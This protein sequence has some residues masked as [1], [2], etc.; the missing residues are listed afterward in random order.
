VIPEARR[1]LASGKDAAAI[2]LLKS[3]PPTPAVRALL[4]D[5]YRIQKRYDAAIEAYDKA[6]SKA[7]GRLAERIL[8]DRAATLAKAGRTTEAIAAWATYLKA[9][10]TGR[11]RAR[12]HLYI[13]TQGIDAEQHL[14][15][16]LDHHN[17]RR[18]ATAALERLGRLFLDGGRL[19]EAGRLFRAHLGAASSRRA[20]AAHVGLMRVKR[21]TGD[22]AGLAKLLDAYRTRFPNGR[23]AK[24][25]ERLSK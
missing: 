20:E 13:A 22:Q 3:A 2:D 11:R 10:P 25:V 23:R 21:A 6:L 1:L 17:T 19:K 4:G 7:T 5:A 24:E 15:A 18:E 16:I 12:A 14:R 9:A 8:A